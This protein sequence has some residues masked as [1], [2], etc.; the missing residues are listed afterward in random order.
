MERKICDIIEYDENK[1]KVIEGT[2]E[3]CCFND[4]PNEFCYALFYTLSSYMPM[5]RKKN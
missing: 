5:L 4:K 2:C 1:L 3:D